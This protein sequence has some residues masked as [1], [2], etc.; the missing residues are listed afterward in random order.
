MLATTAFYSRLA[1]LIGMTYCG[2]ATAGLAQTPREAQGRYRAAFR[3][4]RRSPK[5][6]EFAGRHPR[7]AVYDSIVPIFGMGNFFKEIRTARP[8]SRLT[9]GELIDSLTRA[10]EAQPPSFYSPAV[11]R[12]TRRS[13]LPKG[14][15]MVAFSA[16]SEEFVLAE[17]TRNWYGPARFARVQMF[18]QS[19][20]YLIRFPSQGQPEIIRAMEICYN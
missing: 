16:R 10:D 18:D 17:V 5:F 11:A 8:H 1:I 7:I 12:I 4:I 14:T 15:V 9:D 13:P 2:L 6:Q 3:F 19:I 20:L